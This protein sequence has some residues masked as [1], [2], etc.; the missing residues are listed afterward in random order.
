MS[1]FLVFCDAWGEKA[2]L[3]GAG[4]LSPPHRLL[5]LE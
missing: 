1:V 2:V 5:P 3:P 4:F